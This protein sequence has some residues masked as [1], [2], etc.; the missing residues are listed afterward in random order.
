MDQTQQPHGD[1]EPDEQEVHAERAAS[2]Q[3]ELQQC[4]DLIFSEHAGKTVTE[5]RGLLGD[6]VEA[7]GH[8]RPPITWLEAVS[9]EIAAGHRY[10]TGTH[11]DGSVQPIEG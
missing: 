11:A 3:H 8:P 10:I 1:A 9:E 5:L 4:I 6:A 7:A 2:T